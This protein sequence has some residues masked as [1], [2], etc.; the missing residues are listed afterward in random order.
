[1][2]AQLNLYFIIQYNAPVYWNNCVTWLL[3]ILRSKQFL[4]ITFFFK[5]IIDN[6]SK[7][8]KKN[9]GLQI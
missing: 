2:Y 5:I 8:K 4:L 1:M 3:F 9:D 7:G 6:N